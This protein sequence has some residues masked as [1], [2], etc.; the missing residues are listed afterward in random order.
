[1]IRI[2]AVAR[3]YARAL[4]ELGLE[5]GAEDSYGEELRVLA[6]LFEEQPMLRGL[7]TDP[8]VSEA[9]R[10][11]VLGALVEAAQL[12]GPVTALLGEML[13]HHRMGGLPEVAPAY[14]RLLDEHRGIVEAGVVSAEELD[15]KQ[16][17]LL[18][19][20]LEGLTSKKVRLRATRDPELLGGLVVKI[21]DVVYDGSL[22]KRLDQARREL[23]TD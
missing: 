7:L 13:R 16:Q 1:M 18:R 2:G 3:R 8:L 12:S 21:G 14:A 9:R 20:K 10:E 4:L 22:R 6:E 17:D 5:Q 11:E 19:E 15:P 23:M